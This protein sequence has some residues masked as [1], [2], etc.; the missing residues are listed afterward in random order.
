LL[1]VLGSEFGECRREPH[2]LAAGRAQRKLISAN[3]V[4]AHV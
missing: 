3:C 2:G 1:G 4:N